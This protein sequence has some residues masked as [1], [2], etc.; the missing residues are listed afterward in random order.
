MTTV[1]VESE[2]QRGARFVYFQY[3]ISVIV[4]TFRRSSAIFFI[5]AGKSRFW[6]GLPYT[7]ISLFLGWWGI[8]WGPVRTVQALATDL[9]GGKDVTSQVM[10][11]QGSGRPVTI[12]IPSKQATAQMA[13]SSA[14]QTST[15]GVVG[16]YKF[17]GKCGTRMSRD[18]A[19]CPACGK[20]QPVEPPRAA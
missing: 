14:A 10:A 16:D 19:F 18:A 15:P 4:I 11:S 13:S 9:R 1:Q 20:A 3:C 2:V 7:L 6:K 8:P 5:P 17:C 12:T